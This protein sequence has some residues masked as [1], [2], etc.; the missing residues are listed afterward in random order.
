MVESSEERL[1]VLEVLSGTLQL[2]TP[3]IATD[4]GRLAGQLVGRLAGRAEPDIAELLQA[5]RDQARRPWI[6]PLTASLTAPGGSLERILAGHTRA[7]RAVAVSPDGRWVVSGGADVTVRVWDIASGRLERMLD[8]Y[9]G[10]VPVD[11]VAITPDGRRVVSGSLDGKIRVHD[12][13]SGRL[14]RTLEDDTSRL[15]AVAVSPDGQWIGS[16]DNS[17]VR[18]WNLASGRLEHVFDITE[19]IA[20]GSPVAFAPDGSRIVSDSN[21]GMIRAWNLASGQLE[22][23]FEPQYAP[24]INITALAVTPDGSRIVS[25]AAPRGQVPR[26]GKIHVWHIESGQLERVL[27]TKEADGY[28]FAFT[29][30]GS[31]IVW[32][33]L[34][35]ILTWDFESG[36]QEGPGL[37]ESEVNASAVTPDGCRVVTGDAAGTVRVWALPRGQTEASIQATKLGMDTS[38]D[39]VAPKFGVTGVAVTS[40][41]RR[42]VSCDGSE[43]VRLWDL[44]SGE[45]EHELDG[46]EG[47]RIDAVA[48]TRDG[49]RVIS[50]SNGR[51]C[52]WNI[53]SGQLEPELELEGKGYARALAVT[54][55]GRRVVRATERNVQ[56]W[57]LARSRLERTLEG[58]TKWVSA[59]VVTPDGRRVV[60]SDGEVGPEAGTY[61]RNDRTIRVWDLASGRLVR[62]LG[63]DGNGATT[64]AATP[65]GRRIISDSLR[66]GGWGGRE[67]AVRVWDLASGQLE[68]SL[69]HK[70]IVYAV[71]VTPDG[72]LAV[73]VE[74]DALRVWDIAGG[75]EL[76]S[77]IP[78]PGVYLLSCC[79]V[80]T[81]ASLIV[82]GGSRGGIHVLRLLEDKPVQPGR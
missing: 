44:G 77:W 67:C 30:D 3:F 39:A 74:R 80:P 47:S 4:P 55:D 45:L 68:R 69:I 48:V 1:A 76:A 15:R 41:G 31:R 8:G 23:T 6:C 75:E 49:R 60:S 65:D 82:C 2:S 66:G 46:G 16:R 37:Y 40:D 52:I 20:G 42:I 29:P 35:Q 56:V 58:H 21:D 59:V 9:S 73:S 50:T 43:I 71:A 13:A 11:S 72:R 64:L 26:P 7:V 33:T 53:A 10:F 24:F 25:Y 62:K 28:L 36:Q 51:I 12:F 18:V 54:P 63:D 79:T 57:D 19:S 22:R 34:W 14:E 81:D 17:A 61:I 5:I 38:T 70:G 32:H 27:E 78:D